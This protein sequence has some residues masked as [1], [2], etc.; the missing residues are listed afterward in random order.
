MCAATGISA[1]QGPKRGLHE[2][3][4]LQ[5]SVCTEPYYKISL[6]FLGVARAKYHWVGHRLPVDRSDS[7]LLLLP[8]LKSFIQR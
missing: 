2:A 3:Q 4:P 6:N 8:I 5:A 1:L 7:G